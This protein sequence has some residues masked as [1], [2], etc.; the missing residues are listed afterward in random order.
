M[1]KQKGRFSFRG[2]VLHMIPWLHITMILAPL[3]AAFANM[4][5]HR[6]EL[7]TA[8]YFY[9]AL[10]FLLPVAILSIAAERC[11]HFWLYLLIAAACAG[12]TLFLSGCWVATALVL[13]IAAVRYCARVRGE[14]SFLDAPHVPVAAVF[15]LPFVIGGYSMDPFLQEISVILAAVYVVMSLLYHGLNRLEKYISINRNMNNFPEQR[16]SLSGGTIFGV[17]A[18]VVLLI[19]IPVIVMN[20]SFIPI[21]PDADRN[22][23]PPQIEQP[24]QTHSMYGLQALLGKDYEVKTPPVVLVILEKIL[25]VVIPVGLAAFLLFVLIRAIWHMSRN[26]LATAKGRNGIPLLRGEEDDEIESTLHLE[27]ENAFGISEKKLR[28]F[29]FSPD[30][31]IRKKYVKTIRAASKERPQ[32]WQSPAEI[33]D[34]A[35][36]KN[37][38]L[39]QLYE[40][41]RY[42]RDGCTKE[43]WGK[44]K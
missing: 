8:Y 9:R 27:E 37:P 28:F 29:D 15:I 26:F 33:E 24:S 6:A 1:K 22:S 38:L 3:Y 2:L 5:Y 7:G 39:H 42:S 34:G 43:E 20:Y 12:G 18:V 13:V 14:E 40:K 23:A 19:A 32:E 35:G 17:T 41:A 44:L 25:M 30:G 11:R 16:I 10:A 31:M 36:V 21:R 4:I